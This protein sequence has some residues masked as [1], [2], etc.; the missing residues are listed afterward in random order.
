MMTVQDFAEKV[1][2]RLTGNRVQLDRWLPAD[3]VAFY[4][5]M[6]DRLVA[7]EAA[8]AALVEGGFVPVEKGAV[9]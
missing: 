5:A 3:R 9:S 1:G 2:R 4:D 8:F 6:P 7:G